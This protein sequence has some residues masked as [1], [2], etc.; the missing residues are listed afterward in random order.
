MAI[1]QAIAEVRRVLIDNWPR[2]L[3]QS[4]TSIW[5]ST[6]IP[7]FVSAGLSAWL[8]FIAARR[9]YVRQR[10]DDEMDSLKAAYNLYFAVCDEM[11]RARKR[12]WSIIE[13]HKT[14]RYLKGPF[15]LDAHDS[16]LGRLVEAMPADWKPHVVFRFYEL[17]SM[18]A[19]HHNRAV[20]IPSVQPFMVARHLRSAQRQG[21]PL[22]HELLSD[23]RSE[24]DARKYAHGFAVYYYDRVQDDSITSL[25]IEAIEYLHVL[26]ER[27][28][29]APKPALCAPS[30]EERAAQFAILTEMM[31]PKGH[32]EG[33][34]D[35]V[36]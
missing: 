23:A 34:Y 5:V 29:A 26:A 10:A 35:G 8:S 11:S 6:V 22:D 2:G 7:V 25:Y 21:G 32:E 3:S 13:N 1:A 20:Q 30:P 16:V 24:Q 19:T 4:P 9:I 36:E 18:V 15:V 31:P 33:P 17:L 28:G 14:A 27:V 12:V